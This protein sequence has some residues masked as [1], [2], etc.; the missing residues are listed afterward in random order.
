M[1]STLPGTPRKTIPLSPDVWEELGEVWGWDGPFELEGRS[2]RHLTP[3]MVACM[4]QEDENGLHTWSMP[5]ITALLQAGANAQALYE[6]PSPDDPSHYGILYLVSHQAMSTLAPLLQAYGTDIDTLDHHGNT[7]FMDS[8]NL[9]PWNSMFLEEAL[10]TLLK[11]GARTDHVNRHGQDI[12]DIARENSPVMEEFLQ[13]ILTG[14]DRDLLHETL[15]G[16]IQ[17]S[18]AN[19]KIRL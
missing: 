16:V 6:S 4:G 10:K 11:L 9:A 17:T 14:R 8:L 7:P 2:S 5:L 1:T 3:L 12:F 15:P 13:R 18:I 19:P